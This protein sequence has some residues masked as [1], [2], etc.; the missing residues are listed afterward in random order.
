MIEKM[1]RRAHRGEAAGQKGSGRRRFGRRGDSAPL[2]SCSGAVAW[3]SIEQRLNKRVEYSATGARWVFR[4]QDIGRKA[5]ELL[6]FTSQN[7]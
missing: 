7:T 1:R 4:V 5:E 6:G 3:L 2:F